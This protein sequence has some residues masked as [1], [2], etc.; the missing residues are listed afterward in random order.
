MG[1]DIM[2]WL[3]IQL[4]MPIQRGTGRK[5]DVAAGSTFAVALFRR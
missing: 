3:G 1:W 5:H 2:C 4:N